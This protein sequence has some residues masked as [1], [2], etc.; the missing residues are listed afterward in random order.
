MSQNMANRPVT[1]QMAVTSEN[2]DFKGNMNRDDLDSRAGSNSPRTSIDGV[3]KKK[4]TFKITS[5]KLNDSAQDGDSMDDLDETHT[6][7]TEDYSSEILDVS[8]ATDYGQE[9]PSVTEDIPISNQTGKEKEKTSDMHSRFRVVKIETKEPFKRGR[10]LCHDFLDPQPQATTVTAEKSETKLDDANSGSSSAG[11][12]IHYIHGVDDPAKNPLLAGA[13]G[14][15]HAHI[16]EG[17]STGQDVFQPIHPA[18]NT[19]VNPHSQVSAVFCNDVGPGLINTTLCQ[20]HSHQSISSIAS[21]DNVQ[22]QSNLASTGPSVKGD[23]GSS[24]HSSH[25]MSGQQNVDS[26]NTGMFMP[27]FSSG[28]GGANPGSSISLQSVYPQAPIQT[29]C[30]MP[31]DQKNVMPTQGQDQASTYQTFMHLGQQIPNPGISQSG[32]SETMPASEISNVNIPKP[33]SETNHDMPD[34]SSMTINAN[35]FVSGMDSE[36]GN[37]DKGLNVIQNPTALSPAL[38]AAVGDLQSPEEDKR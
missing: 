19:A 14:T 24:Q 4:G 13:T 3:P 31:S 36:V 15:I 21:V 30:Q 7:M 22:M 38:A 34:T 1:V 12:S 6:E 8:K 5:V 27:H 37:L 10:W 20:S 17:Q 16:P 35:E 29:S 26:T 32:H 23:G 2:Q 28:P 18:P 33:V 9:T 11:S 25:K